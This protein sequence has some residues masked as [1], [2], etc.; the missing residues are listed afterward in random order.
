VLN[1]SLEVNRL[2]VS[3]KFIKFTPKLTES[4]PNIGRRLIERT[5]L[6]ATM[7]PDGRTSRGS[8]EI[9]RGLSGDA[10]AGV[11]LDAVGKS[12]AVSPT[13]FAVKSPPFGVILS[14]GRSSGAGVF[15]E[16]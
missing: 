15:M 1:P 3:L 13:R 12:L 16:S 10:F 6:E 11:L 7:G 14:G 2:I 8:A 4:T 9:L 5:Y